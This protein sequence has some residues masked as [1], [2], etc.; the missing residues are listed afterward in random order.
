MR[1]H[2]AGD[3]EAA[4]F[5]GLD[6]Q[7][8]LAQRDVRDVDRAV[9]DGRHQDGGRHA[10]A[11]GMH[12]DGQVRR[13]ALKVRHPER[14]VIQAQLA[15]GHVEIH[16]EPGGSRG[17]AGGYIR[18]VRPGAQELGVIATCLC[19][20]SGE[21]QLERV[22]I[23]DGRLGVGH[24]QHGGESASQGRGGAA[25]PVLLVEGAGLAHV[26]VRIDQARKPQH[27]DLAGPRISV[28]NDRVDRSMRHGNP[29]AGGLPQAK[30]P[31]CRSN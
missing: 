31:C 17:Q 25:V 6:E 18:V 5:G 12:H 1:R 28:L 9:V 23:E 24:G 7:N 29:R 19:A 30:G 27:H 8:L 21:A 14:H 20:G 3:R 22:G 4:L 11:F 16:L 10:A 13:P 15:K 2:L 26:N